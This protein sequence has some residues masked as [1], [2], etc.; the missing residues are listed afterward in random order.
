VTLTIEAIEQYLNEHPE[1]MESLRLKTD[2]QGET[3]SFAERRPDAGRKTQSN[4]IQI[5]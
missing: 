2:K 1:A 5:S 4:R 3:I